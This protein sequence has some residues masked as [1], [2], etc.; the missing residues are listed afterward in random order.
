MC[1]GSE[2]LSLT[3]TELIP[4]FV[5][6][7]GTIALVKTKGPTATGHTRS[8]ACVFSQLAVQL[9][10]VPRDRPCGTGDSR[11]SRDTAIQAHTA[12]TA[13]TQPYRRIQ[14]GQQR[15]PGRV[16][17]C[18]SYSHSYKITADI[19]AVCRASNQVSVALAATCW[20]V[21]GHPHV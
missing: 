21:T 19:C 4:T 13:G 5:T 12:G 10:T 16:S 7:G 11:D 20:S 17:C 18:M 9:L 15:R 3:L 6:T 1:L 2:V 8:S 14:Q